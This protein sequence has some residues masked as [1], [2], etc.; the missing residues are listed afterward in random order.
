M[1]KTL[2]SKTFLLTTVLTLTAVLFP[3][4]A[5]RAQAVGE[6]SGA[7]IAQFKSPD[8]RV[9]AV[10]FSPD[11]RLLAAGYGFYDDGGVTIWRVADRAS[12][13][14]PFAR[15]R[16]KAGVSK[17]AFS[18]DGKLFA[19]ATDRGDVLLWTVGSWRSPKTLLMKRGDTTD[20][21]FSPDGATLA[22]SSDKAA[23]LYDLASGRASV[24]AGGDGHR[25]SFN[26]ISFS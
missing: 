8:H 22:Y 9:Q 17:V 23:I 5:A 12:V 2:S 13:A 1:S 15:V 21:S 14:T 18:P 7:L 11:G 20:L 4:T 26:G 24:I 16:S 3:S 19:A 6:Q 10:A 25:D